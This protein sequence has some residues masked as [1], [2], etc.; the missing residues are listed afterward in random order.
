[1]LVTG[2]ITPTPVVCA[3]D[4]TGDGRVDVFDFALFAER[5][6]SAGAGPEDGDFNGDGRVDV[7]DFG[8]LAGEFGCDEGAG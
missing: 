1:M 2:N 3:S 6:G 7:F 4:G 5:F 8:V